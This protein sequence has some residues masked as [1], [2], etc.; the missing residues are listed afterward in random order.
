MRVIRNVVV[1]MAFGVLGLSFGC[2]K[3]PTK[4][5]GDAEA[6]VS[7]AKLAE[8]DIYVPKEYQSA[9]E[10]LAQAKAEVDQKE[11]KLALN[12]AVETIA[13]AETAK[14][15]AITA[16]EEAKI[17]AG[18]IIEDLKAALKEAEAAEALKYYA[19]NY[20]KLSGILKEIESDYAA[21][22]YLDVISKGEVAIADAKE[23]A[24]SSRLAAAEEIRRKAEEEARL[25]AEAEARRKAE[26]D[27]RLAA[28]A[29]ARRIA[30]LKT[31]SHLVNKGECLWAISEY[32][33]I[34]DNPFQWPLIYKANR[35]QISDP[36]LIFP[37]QDFKIPRSA[38]GEEINQALYMA[39][40]RGPWSLYDGR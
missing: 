32:E 7:A 29:E 40:N 14:D 11:Y 9:E 26:E 33:K 16:K 36:D 35:S 23:L 13:L 17:K 10:M 34:Y 1:I 22:K 8:A 5:I 25:A 21:E 38:S 24:A 4:E 20:N 39:R 12:S 2:A 6:A 30:S 15:H 31:P 19:S 3:P 28:E 37:G 18:K 27:A